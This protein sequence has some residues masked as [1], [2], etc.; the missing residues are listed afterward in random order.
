MQVPVVTV[1]T[2]EDTQT[3][4]TDQDEAREVGEQM[5]ENIF[6][7][8]QIFSGGWVRGAAGGGAA[9]HAG[10]HAGGRQVHQGQEDQRRDGESRQDGG[11]AEPRRHQVQ[12]QAEK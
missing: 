9:G 10:Q 3:F 8:L 6:T 7:E 4:Q 5:G 2:T 1:D 11:A 12:G